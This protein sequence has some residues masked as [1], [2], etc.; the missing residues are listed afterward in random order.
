M[1]APAV[2]AVPGSVAFD[3][4]HDTS[5][6]S[7]SASSMMRGSEVGFQHAAHHSPHTIEDISNI[8]LVT[9]SGHPMSSATVL[10]PP[11]NTGIAQPAVAGAAVPAAL[12]TVLYRLSD[13][14]TAVGGQQQP[15]KRQRLGAGQL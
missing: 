14:P 5:N 6:M 2:M 3:F 15:A 11:Y 4:D 9:S 7:S 10:T 1:G 8:L 12:C 13:C